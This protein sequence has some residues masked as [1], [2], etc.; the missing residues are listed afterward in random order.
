MDK[1]YIG[2][3]EVVSTVDSGKQTPLG[4][5]ILEVTFEDG[6]KK[7]FT[8]K[9]YNNMVS[10]EEVDATTLRDRKCKPVVQEI[11]ALMTEANLTM[12]DI[13]YTVELTAISVDEN[14][15]N[16]VNKV[17]KVEYPEDRSLLGIDSLL[18]G[19]EPDAY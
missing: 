8:S 6:T 18:K 15:K 11:L 14:S 10:T 3:Q 13:N 12:G 17:F 9:S 1:K 7:L 5:S 16:A 2:K 19:N 4:F